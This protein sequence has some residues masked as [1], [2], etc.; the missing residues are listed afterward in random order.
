MVV[1]GPP[2]SAVPS[3]P[4]TVRLNASDASTTGPLVTDTG[5]VTESVRVLVSVTVS[6]TLL[7]P[8]AA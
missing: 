1:H 3:P 7:L 5:L 4:V 6:V 8:D 2:V